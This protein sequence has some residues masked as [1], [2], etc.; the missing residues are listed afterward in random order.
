MKKQQHI[1]LGLL[2]AASIVPVNS[3]LNLGKYG[4]ALAQLT[5]GIA[6]I[7]PPT[8]EISGL[9]VTI[10]TGGDDLRGG[11]VAYGVVELSGGRKEKVNL[12]G[13]RNWGNNSTNKVS[14][15]LPKGTKLGDLISFT[16]EH[17]GKPRNVLDSYD[18]WNVD[19]LKVATPKTCSA[20][21][22]LANQSG[23]P[24]VRLTG[25]KTFQDITLSSSSSA[26]NT[27]VS[28]LQVT[29][30]TGGDDLRGGAVAYGVIKL[31]NGTTLS[32]V[33]LNGG[34][35]WGNNSSNTVSIPLPSGIKIGDLASLRIEHDGA[36]RNPFESYDNWNVDRVRV[37]TPE[38]CSDAVQLIN[39]IGRP[40]V[41]FTGG[42][43]FR[44]Y[45]VNL[46]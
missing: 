3:V 46:R 30:T 37:V 8:M 42:D 38:A 40:L 28:K 39:K 32:K 44:K 2:L 15:P 23:K 21:V 31:Q 14:L 29:I 4:S 20:G 12:N 5:V 18:N 22:Q 16:L 25:G 11:S 24:F 19:Q 36:P 26:K 35:G 17:D 27:P 45:S 33:N 10:T 34:R 7:M 13:G 6:V 1:V 43:T 9:E 41:R